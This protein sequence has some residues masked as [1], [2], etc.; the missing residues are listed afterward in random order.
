MATLAK[1]TVDKWL[2]THQTNAMHFSDNPSKIVAAQL[3]C[4]QKHKQL[5]KH[6]GT[7]TK[8]TMGIVMIFA[9]GET[10]ENW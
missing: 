3:A 1:E 8:P 10:N 7:I 6:M 9:N 5:S 4:K 2:K